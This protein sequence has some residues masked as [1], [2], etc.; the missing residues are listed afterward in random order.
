M[1]KVLHRILP[2]IKMIFKSQKSKQNIKYN[3][4]I[5]C[6]NSTDR[7]DKQTLEQKI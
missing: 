3:V 7:N 4:E 2:M 5:K 1:H 6:Y